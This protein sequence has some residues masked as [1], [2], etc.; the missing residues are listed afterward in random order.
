MTCSLGDCECTCG[1]ADR[2]Y[3]VHESGLPRAD[4]GQEADVQ[5]EDQEEPAREDGGSCQLGR[6]VQRVQVSGEIVIMY[7]KN[8]VSKEYES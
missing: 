4:P 3:V 6:V 8:A 5:H 2:G 7:W 1:P